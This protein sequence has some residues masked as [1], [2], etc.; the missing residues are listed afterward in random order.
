VQGKPPAAVPPGARAPIIHHP[1]VKRMLLWMKSSTEAMR[2]LGIYAASRL[3]LAKHSSDAALREAAQARGDLLIPI[4][5]GWC[6]ELG[7]DV[8]S[9]GVQ[10]HG[11]MGF[12]EE[13]GA[14]QYYRDVRITAIYE[15]TT[16]IQS[17]DLINRKIAR[18]RAAT[19]GALIADMQSELRAIDSTNAST[20][21]TRQAALE[22]VGLLHESTDAILSALAVTPERALAVSVPYLELAGY[23]IGGW[24]MAKSSAI[25]AGKLAGADADFYAGKIR[26]ALFYAKQ[27]LPNAL[28]LARVVKDGAASVL[29]TDAALL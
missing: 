16:G 9:L 11:G 28:A 27:V 17:N 15:G 24:L 13:T 8:T 23:V 12:I 25:A 22:A 19:M 7:I 4:V 18:D 1:D 5:K 21:E 3:D 29:E 14:A 10:V 20:Q 6:T 26:T 2:A